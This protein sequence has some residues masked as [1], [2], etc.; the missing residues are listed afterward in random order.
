[1]VHFA[2]GQQQ[3]GRPVDAEEVVVGE[4]GAR[5]RRVDPVVAAEPDPRTQLVVDAGVP[6][7]DQ[8]DDDADDTDSQ[9]VRVVGARLGA[10]RELGRA[11]LQQRHLPTAHLKQATPRELGQ[12][13]ETQQ[14]VETDVG[15]RRAE[16]SV[17]G[18]RR[19]DADDVDAERPRAR[20]VTTQQRR[21]GHDYTLLQVAPIDPGMMIQVRKGR[22][23]G[24]FYG[25]LN[26]V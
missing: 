16:P 10:L 5:F 11:Y 22:Y 12:A 20:V 18:I 8:D 14:P 1:M 23:I 24:H 17:E 21:V 15:R 9:R 7:D 26:E 4:S 13:T 6:V 19:E 25:A 3:H 2:D